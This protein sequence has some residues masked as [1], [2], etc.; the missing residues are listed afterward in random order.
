MMVLS[1]MSKNGSEESA[2]RLTG[3]VGRF[4]RD[5]NPSI[6]CFIEVVDTTYDLEAGILGSVKQRIQ[7][8]DSV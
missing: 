4:H 7:A 5:A 6:R 3:M 1:W 2:W 8:A